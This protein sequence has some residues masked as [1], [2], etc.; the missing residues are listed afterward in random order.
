MAGSADVMYF[1]AEFSV[2]SPGDATVGELAKTTFVRTGRV[3]TLGLQVGPG[4]GLPHPE[5]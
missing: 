4:P 1:S 3:L 5:A 2:S